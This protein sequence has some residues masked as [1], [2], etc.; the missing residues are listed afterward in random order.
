MQKARKQKIFPRFSLSVLQIIFLLAGSTFPLDLFGAAP[1]SN[2]HLHTHA[3]EMDSESTRVTYIG[4]AT[5]LIEMDQLRILTDPI[6]RSRVLHLVRQGPGPDPALFQDIDVVLISH[7][8]WDHLDIPSLRRIT[9]EPLFIV[10]PGVDKILA[11]Y[12]FTRVQVVEVGDRIEFGELTITATPAEHD[13]NRL[14]YLGE[15]QACGYLIEGSQRIYFAGD[16]ERYPE[17]AE[18]RLS[19]DLALLPVWGWGPT[20]GEGHLD[21]AGA[22]AATEIIQPKVAIPIHWGTL[23]PIGLRF[24]FPSFLITPPYDYKKLAEKLAPEVEVIILPPGKSVYLE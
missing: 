23:Y 8:H 21:P 7:A 10:P 22:A 3:S 2:Y 24:L 14:R 6:L 12:G 5:T 19:L 16:T 13:G 15:E 4:H 11:K 20:L 18:M 17:M 1:E 9:G